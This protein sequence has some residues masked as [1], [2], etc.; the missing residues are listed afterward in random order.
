[1]SRSPNPFGGKLPTGDVPS[2][3]SSLRFCQGNSPLPGVRQG[4]AAEE[5]LVA[6]GE[7][8]PFEATASGE[9]PF[10]LRRELLSIPGR[11]SLDVLVGDV[12]DGVTVPAVDGAALAGRPPPGCAGHVG[13]P[14]AEVTEI[15]R[16]G[17]P[18]EDERAC[19][20]QLWIR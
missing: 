20:Q 16:S 3:P 17:R 7:G 6:P 8:G 11:V 12:N 1:M 14:A 19:H 15:D 18:A 10:G 9:L 5:V 13:P 2:N 4:L